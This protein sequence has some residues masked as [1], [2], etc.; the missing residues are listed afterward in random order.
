MSIQVEKAN[1]PQIKKAIEWMF[2]GIS[3]DPSGMEGLKNSWWQRLVFQHLLGPRMFQGQMDSFVAVESS[4]TAEILGFLIVQYNGDMAGTFDW[5]VQ[6]S[7]EGQELTAQEVE[8][9]S[10]LIEKALDWI[11]EH[12]KHYPYFYFGLMSHSS[13]TLKAILED[14]GLWLPDYQLW[15]MVASLP[16]EESPSM[17]EELT[18]SPQIPTRFRSQA[19][20]L[21][22]Y[23][24]I[25]PEDEDEADFA[26]DLDAI[27]ALHTMSLNRTK[28]FS[29]RQGEEELGFIQY[30]QWKDEMRLLLA[31]KPN[32]W[33]TEIERKMVA[34]LPGILGQTSGRV[35]LRTFSQQ[36]LER[37]RS[38]F[39]S[40]G[41]SW[42]ESPWQRW[43]VSL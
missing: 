15:Q 37:S 3:S 43:M 19:L 28:L 42:T 8:V 13:P 36:H 30:N 1:G 16:L 24:Y 32:L 41:F 38:Q 34:A 6:R 5:A 2:A 26:E 39:E 29:V 17:P 40:I 10:N 21:L 27:A 31:L 35:R 18:V 14:E 25:R 7:L 11:E 20:E 23:D 22:R 12:K 9:L 33:G 4:G